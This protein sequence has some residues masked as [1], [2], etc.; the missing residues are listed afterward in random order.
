MATVDP[1]HGF[2]GRKSDTRKCNGNLEGGF[3]LEEVER[4]SNL[5]SFRFLYEIYPMDFE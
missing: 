1:G 2:R 3:Q 4:R 5:R